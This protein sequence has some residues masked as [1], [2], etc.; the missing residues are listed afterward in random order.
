M[1]K[2][3]GYRNKS[4]LGFYHLL[5]LI[6]CFVFVLSNI[7]ASKI[8]IIFDVYLDT[9]TLY[10][11]ILYIVNDII[12][13]IYGFTSSR[14]VI[15]MAISTNIIFVLFLS[16]SVSLPSVESIG[17]NL[18][19]DQVFSL[20]PRILMASVISFLIGE[21]VNSVMLAKSKIR[22][23]GKSFGYRAITSTAVGVSVESILFSTIAFA[24]KFEVDELI[25]MTTMLISIKILYEIVTMP[26]TSKI[27]SY[28]K[29]YENMDFYDTD[30][31]FT[32]LPF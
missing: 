6:F 27:V 30:T 28:L 16:L 18:A 9:G 24:G 14:K 1:N 22:F 23:H 15:W 25:G 13:E 7:A 31:K 20:S 3:Y 4:Y 11:P 17:V 10:F 32:I 12:T 8:G 29:K 21:Y 26:I 2:I 19:F 5:A